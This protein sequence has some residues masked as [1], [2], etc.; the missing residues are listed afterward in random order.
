MVGASLPD[1]IPGIPNRTQ[2]VAGVQPIPLSNEDIAEV[3]IAADVTV[4]VIDE[5][6]LPVAAA[7]ADLQHSARSNREDSLAVGLTARL[8]E[9]QGVG[10]VV[11]GGAPVLVAPKDVLVAVPLSEQPVLTR[12]KGERQLGHPTTTGQERAPA[13]VA[14]AHH[15]EQ[16]H[17]DP[18]GQVQHGFLLLLRVESTVS[19]K[20]KEQIVV[21]IPLQKTHVLKFSLNFSR[22]RNT[23]PRH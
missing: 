6:R 12:G 8:R 21:N 11:V 2:A 19:P 23:M 22:I 20:F 5:D 10:V 14:G 18:L 3:G 15:H 7:R 13:G 1:N 16:G 4:I 17:Q 9:V